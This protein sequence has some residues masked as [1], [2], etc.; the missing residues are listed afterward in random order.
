MMTN[1]ATIEGWRPGLASRRWPQAASLVALLLCLLLPVPAGAQEQPPKVTPR[2]SRVEPTAIP[3]GSSEVQLRVEGEGFTGASRVVVDGVPVPTDV[4]GPDRLQA[5][6]PAAMLAIAKYLDVRVGASGREVADSSPVV[7]T[8]ENPVPL[9]SVVEVPVLVVGEA[10][11]VRLYGKAFRPDSTIQV[12]GTTIETI[13][14]SGEELSGTIPATALASAGVLA[15]NVATPGPGG[16][17]SLAGQIVV[18]DPVFPGRFIAF[19][20]N[21]RHGRNHIYLLDRRRNRVDPLEEAN[22]ANG[23]DAYPSISADGRF[24]AF[25]SDRH[26]GQDDIFLFDRQKRTLDPLREANHPT[27]FDG[28]PAISA[29]ARFI[30]FES[31]RLGKPKIF[32]FDLRTRALSELSQA[33][34][35]TADDGLAAISN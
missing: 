31:D 20:S 3:V 22:S 7:L 30:V 14:R 24:I 18:T 10:A 25:Q 29:D 2:V 13:Y 11:P 5:H 33:N 26:G 6:L 28:F 4:L 17:L 12:A 27:A 1:G 32:L 15:V 23:T 19:T 21:R 34:E 8:V 9:L 35:A 16:G